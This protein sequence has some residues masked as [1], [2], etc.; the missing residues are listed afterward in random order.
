MFIFAAAN[1]MAMQTS[2][3]VAQSAL[4]P[5]QQRSM[6]DEQSQLDEIL[7]ELLSE[8][9]FQPDP[10]AKVTGSVSPNYGSITRQSGGGRTML[11]WDAMN[12]VSCASG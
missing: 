5:M 3:V 7:N 6:L 8:Q 2:S 9:M 12:Q 10:N 1:Q 4:T 11:S